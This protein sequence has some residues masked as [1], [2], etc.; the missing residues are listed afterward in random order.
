[1]WF[2]RSPVVFSKKARISSRSRNPYIIID[3]APMSI[4]LVAM[5]TKWEDTRLS[6]VISTRIA[7][8]RGGISTPSNFSTASE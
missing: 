4:P 6:S 1:M 7:L 8:A 3:N 5:A 2:M